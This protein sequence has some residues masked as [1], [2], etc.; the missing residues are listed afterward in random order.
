MPGRDLP[1]HEGLG[2]YT[3]MFLVTFQMI[4]PAQKKALQT[5]TVAP[6]RARPV[7]P[8]APAG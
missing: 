3:S 8:R 4:S 7:R 2:P 5:A 1:R 6:R